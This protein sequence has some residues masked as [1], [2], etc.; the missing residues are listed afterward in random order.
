M[1]DWII[2]ALS[3]VPDIIEA[4]F[5]KKREKKEQASRAEKEG[6]AE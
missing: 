4:L 2:E 6:A 1:L 3:L 5:H